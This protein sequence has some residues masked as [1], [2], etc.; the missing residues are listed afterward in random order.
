MPPV[1]NGRV[2]LSYKS[3]LFLAFLAY[4]SFASKPSPIVICSHYL[5]PSWV[6]NNTTLQYFS[7][8]LLTL[9]CSLNKWTA[10]NSDITCLVVFSLFLVVHLLQI[11]NSHSIHLVLMIYSHHKGDPGQ[12]AIACEVGEEGSVSV[13]R[14]GLLKYLL[15]YFFKMCYLFLSW[16]A[17]TLYFPLWFPYNTFTCQ[18]N[19]WEWEEFL[20]YLTVVWMMNSGKLSHLIVSVSVS[21]SINQKPIFI[22]F[23]CLGRSHF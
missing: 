15:I 22:L 4:L 14:S 1:Q 2:C 19:T 7:Y 8:C 5:S 17:F 10:D 11:S 18:C 6:R 21:Q 13:W 12:F 3:Y 23:I 20:F 9:F 16:R